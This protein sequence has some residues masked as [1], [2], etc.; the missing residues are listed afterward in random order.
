MNSSSPEMKKLS[1]HDQIRQLEGTVLQLQGQNKRLRRSNTVLIL[2]N[3]LV[4]SMMAFANKILLDKNDKLLSANSKVIRTN[5][6]LVEN[7]SKA[8]PPLVPG[9]TLLCFKAGN[10]C[11]IYGL[12][13]SPDDIFATRRMIQ[14]YVGQTS[15]WE[16][17]EAPCDIPEKWT[18]VIREGI[19]GNYCHGYWQKRA[20]ATPADNQPEQK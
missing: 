17:V 15:A 5:Q 2:S 3:I 13:P 4:L 18:G 7:L 8:G 20:R 6:V 19:S 12:G 16:Y 1:S 14:Q 10:I 11:H 9:T